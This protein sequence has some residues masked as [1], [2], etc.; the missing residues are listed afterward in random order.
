MIEFV[1]S[2]A[3]RAGKLALY[4][5]SCMNSS[6]I[7]RKDTDKDLV[8]DADRKVE[9]FIISELKKSYPD[10]DVLGEESG[11]SANKSEYCWI[12]DPIDGTTS[13][14]HGF[15]QWSVSI[16][17]HR[18]GEPLLGVVYAPVF[19]ELYYAEAGRGAYCNGV[20]LTVSKRD[21]LIDSIATFGIFCVRAGWTEEENMKFASRLAP[22]LCDIR[23]CGSA[24]LDFCYIARGIGDAYWE[25]SLMPYDF[26]AGMLIVTEAGGRVSDLYGG[27]EF[28]QKGIICTNGLIHEQM[29]A[30]FYDFQNLR[31]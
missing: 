31:R 6:N 17:L 10:F 13:F 19:D 5:Q 27:D 22:Q 29:L 11:M 16:G 26:A 18:N 21:K 9:Q 2:V 28:P 24:A 7:H 3:V 15:P 25:L 23:K 30:N 20:R 14:A 4:E 12:I 8:T 1:K